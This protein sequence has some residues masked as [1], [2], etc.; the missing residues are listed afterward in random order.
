[1]EISGKTKVCGIIGD[2]VDHSLSPIMHNAAFSELKLNFI[3][4]A[5]P[6]KRAELHKAMTD[7]RGLKVHGLNVTMP[8][9][10][11]VITHLDDIDPTARFI[12]AVNTI[13][14]K[15]GSL[16]G[17]NTDGLGA[18]NALK[19]NGIDLERK[20]VLLL[21]AGGAAKAIACSLI[22]EVDELTILNRTCAKAKLLAQYL[23]RW[24]FQI[25]EGFA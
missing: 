21:G 8:H 11:A 14:N 10:I 22:Q 19:K 18:M 3:Y 16:V 2:P 5:F 15:Q 20:K 9:K 13:L 7:I 24:S 25:L 12:G 17:F 6:V 23:L 1:M 4:V